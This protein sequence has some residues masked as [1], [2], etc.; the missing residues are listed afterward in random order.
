MRGKVSEKDL[1]D[2]IETIQEETTK[3]TVSFYINLLQLL[4]LYSNIPQYT[5]RAAEPDSDE[6]L[7]KGL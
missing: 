4:Y 1:I 7:L 3:I 6:E 5:R 2:L